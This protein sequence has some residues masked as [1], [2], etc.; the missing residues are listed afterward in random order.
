MFWQ[1][2]GRR[3]VWRDMA[4]LQR[5]MNRL[6]DNMGDGGRS[7][8]FPPLNVWANEE[9]AMI[10]AEIPGVKP[11]DLDISVVGDTLTLSGS[12]SAENGDDGHT[13]HRR[14]RWQGNFSRTLQLPF[15]ISTEQ[16]DAAFRNGVLQVTLPR[17]E[18][19]KPHRISINA[20]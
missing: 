18:E 3:S 19:D 14:E 7:S 12:R 5:E 1:N 6:I 20:N 17:A 4:R 10:T 16:V 2:V 11:D 13:Y 9:N 8:E 15:R